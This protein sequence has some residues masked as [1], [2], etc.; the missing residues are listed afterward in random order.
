MLSVQFCVDIDF[1]CLFFV[2]VLT[3]TVNYYILKPDELGRE[4]NPD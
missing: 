4:A 1:F 3:Q 2:S